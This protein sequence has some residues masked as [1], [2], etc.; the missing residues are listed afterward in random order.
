MTQENL[1][2]A[3]D[4]AGSALDYMR[5]TKTHMRDNPVWSPKLIIP[6]IPFEFTEWEKEQRSWREAV[7]LFDQTHH[8]Q[9]LIISGPDA[10]KFISHMACNNLANA[11]PSRAFQIICVAPGGQM[12][13]DGILLQLEEH[14]F[15]AVGP[16]ILN[17]L[18]YNAEILDFDVTTSRDVRSRVYANG[19]AEDRP[20]CRY[21][22]QGPK[23]WQLIEKLNGGPVGDVPFFHL[24]EIKVGKHVMQALRHG[25]AGTA[26]LEI[27]GPWEARE[28]IRGTILEMGEEFGIVEVGAAAYLSSAIESGWVQAVLPAIFTGDDMLAYRQWLPLTELEPLLRLSGSQNPERLDE[29]Y[30]TPFDLG[31]GRLVHFGHEFVGRDALQELSTGPKLQKVTLEWNADDTA[32]VIKEMLTPGGKNVKFLHFPA[33]CDKVD[34]QYYSTTV[35]DRSV[36]SSHY[37]AYLA[38]ERAMLTLALLDESV[39]IGDEVVLHWGEVGGGYGN[40]KYPG[41]DIMPIRATVSPAPYS[42]VA[43]EEYRKN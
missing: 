7:A 39:K 31:Y 4:K 13:G 38:T 6:Q 40:Y 3:I 21:Q 1:Q 25:M 17:W 11:N 27:W 28:E 5:S 23:A 30:R 43:R 34:P 15:A 35:G 18:A 20:E 12:I 37:T 9:S 41:T 33:M 42:R 36:G 22:I 24:T 2:T 29:L 10:K 16:F 26:G 14:K 32:E 19:W 8:M